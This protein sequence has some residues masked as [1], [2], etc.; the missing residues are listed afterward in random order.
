MNE[1]TSLTGRVRRVYYGWWVLASTFLLGVISG[2]IFNHSNAIFFGPIR[3]DLGLT[4]AQTS[5]I[6]ALSRAE[7]SVVGPVVGRLVDKLGARPMI[8]FGGMLAS[9]GFIALYWVHSYWLFLLIFVGVVST[10]KSSGLGQVLIGAVNRWFIKH[11][12]LAMAI[13]ITGFSSGGAILLPLITLGVHTIGWRPVMLYSGIFMAVVLLPLAMVIRHSPESMGLEPDGGTRPTERTGGG[14]HSAGRTK[15][16]AE[17][18]FTVRE[19]LRSRT[20]WILLVA[21]VVRITL[22][23]AISVH[24]VEMMVWKGMDRE[25]AGFMFSLMFFLSIPMRLL[26]GGLGER[27]PLQPLLFGGMASAGLG[28]AA[29][30]LVPGNLAIYLFVMLMAVEQGGSTLNWVALGDFFG[31]SSFATLMGIMSTCFNLGM[32]IS[33]I[34]AGWVFDH[35]ESYALVLGSFVPLYLVSGLIFLMA[36]KPALPQAR[37][38][39]GPRSPAAG[40][41]G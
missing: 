1:P 17:V 35:T 6:F 38:T 24:A 19:A 36:R 29:L 11:R 41:P 32:L 7:G 14:G 15:A 26:A 25:M 28:A 4:S 39:P 21:S 9:V 22:W 34:Y 3:Q 10:G 30:L 13:C 16:G 31:R 40:R 8:I 18:D 5:L 23:G 37:P 20:Y 12:S 33:P 27:L 2:G